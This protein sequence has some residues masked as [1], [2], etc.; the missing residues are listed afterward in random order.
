LIVTVDNHFQRFTTAGF[1][2]GTGPRHKGSM[3]FFKRP[4]LTLEIAGMPSLAKTI[5]AATKDSGLEVEASEN[6]EL[7]HGV[8]VPLRYIVPHTDIPIIPVLTQPARGCVPFSAR[9]FGEALGRVIRVDRRRIGILATGG[10]SHWLDPG[11]FGRIDVKFDEYVLSMVRAGRGWSLADLDP[12]LLLEHGQYELPNWLIMMGAIG[13]GV[14]GDVYAYEAT[15]GSGTGWTVACMQI[16]G[17]VEA[18]R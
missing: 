17:P 6:V 4:D 16:P 15:P 3:E 12:Y 7:D 8:I 9:A 2:V 18:N 13:P 11:R 14:R 10:L 5:V 1:V